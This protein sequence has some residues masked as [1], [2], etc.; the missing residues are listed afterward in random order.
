MNSRIPVSGTANSGIK[1]RPFL[2]DLYAT[3]VGKKYVM[4]AT[5]FMLLEFVF[6]HMI[7]NLKMLLG[8]ADLNSYAELV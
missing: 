3:S 7:G 4:G 5:G 1:R 2:L 8:A 6:F